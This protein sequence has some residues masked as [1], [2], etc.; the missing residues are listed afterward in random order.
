VVKKIRLWLWV[1]A[2]ARKCS[3]GRDDEKRIS[4]SIFKQP[5]ASSLRA[6]R[7]NPDCHRGGI[8]DCFVADAPRNDA[9]TYAR[10]LAAPCA[11]AL[12]ITTSL[13]KTE[14]AGKAGCPPH[15][16][17][18]CEKNA[19]GRNHRCRRDH[20]GLPC[21]VVYGLLRALPGEPGFFATVTCETRQRLRKLD[22]SVGAPG[23]HDF[24]VRT[25]AVRLAAPARPP[26][27]A[28][29]VRD[30]AYAPL[31]ECRTRAGCG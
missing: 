14:G 28:L 12:P 9:K 3:L 7:S 26:H 10:I 5:T 31:D 22:A 18:P 20:S 29:N 8:L 2:R 15:P 16:R 19:R 24:A 17:P 27:P 6:K 4:D 11:R 13:R 25:H 30:D 21:A 1:P 23:P